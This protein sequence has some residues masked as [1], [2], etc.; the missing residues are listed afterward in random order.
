MPWMNKD[1]AGMNRQTDAW[2]V[3]NPG[4]MWVGDRRRL[5]G[6]GAMMTE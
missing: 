4:R 1:Q 3:S 6:A 2:D 5:P